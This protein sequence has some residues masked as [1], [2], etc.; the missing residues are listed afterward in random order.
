[1]HPEA[2]EHLYRQNIEALDT[3]YSSL[4]KLAQQGAPEAKEKL[5]EVAEMRARITGDTDYLAQQ[6]KEVDGLAAS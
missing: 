5:R 4:L 1:M 2:I 3:L 6:Q